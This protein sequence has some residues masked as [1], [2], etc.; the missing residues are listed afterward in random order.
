MGVFEGEDESPFCL[1]L[2]ITG[3]HEHHE[4]LLKT[5]SG[6]PLACPRLLD[7]GKTNTIQGLIAFRFGT[8]A[9]RRIHGKANSWRQSIVMHLVSVGSLVAF[10]TNICHMPRG[11]LIIWSAT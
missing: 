3:E 5:I 2:A 6:I 8:M 10:S 11:P 9:E 4:V 1:W 7:K